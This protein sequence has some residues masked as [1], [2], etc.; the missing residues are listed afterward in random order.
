MLYTYIF[1]RYSNAIVPSSLIFSLRILFGVLLMMHGFDKLNNYDAL[2]TAF[3]S[4]LGLG[5]RISLLSI[6]FVEL[7][8]SLAFIVGF[9][10]RLAILPMIVAM[11][12]AF[13]WV[14]H[15]SVVQGE[16]AFIYL[17]VFLLLALTGPGRYS[18]DNLVYNYIS[19]R[20]K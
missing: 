3:P 17:V 15:A 8:C 18:I 1:P 16:L 2:V 11:F 5:S 14:H 10:Y 6:L 20:C 9:L 4:V 13:V 12:I 19:N 7:V